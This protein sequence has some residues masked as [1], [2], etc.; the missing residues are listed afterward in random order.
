MSKPLP[1]R[2]HHRG[3]NRQARER[4]YPQREPYRRPHLTT[5]P[6]R[7]WGPTLH[8]GRMPTD[9]RRGIV[10]GTRRTVANRERAADR[11]GRTV[12]R[13]ITLRRRR[14]FRAAL[15]LGRCPCGFG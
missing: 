6:R 5:L 7:L 3:L 2:L 12:G 9:R 10:D 11:W 4:N 15:A 1:P 14:S 8:P 13:R